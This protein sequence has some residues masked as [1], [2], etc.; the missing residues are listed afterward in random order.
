MQKVFHSLN[1]FAPTHNLAGKLSVAGHCGFER[2][3]HSAGVSQLPI[4]YIF[5]RQPIY[6]V[7]YAV[8]SF[9]DH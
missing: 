4:D 6:P 8:S 2:Q 5:H 3:C 7:Q 1:M 9:F